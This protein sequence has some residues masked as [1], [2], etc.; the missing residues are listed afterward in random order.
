M[1]LGD[2]SPLCIITVVV[3]K[4][5][6][7]TRSNITKVKNADGCVTSRA[8]SNG[9]VLEMGKTDLVQSTYLSDS[10]KAWNKVPQVIKDCNSIWVAKKPIKKFVSDL[11]I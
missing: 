8:I 6:D 2:V 5:R 3:M 4:D 7:Q 10:C 11:P 1:C 9:D